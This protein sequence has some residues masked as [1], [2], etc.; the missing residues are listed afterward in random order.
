M[1]IALCP[2]LRFKVNPFCGNLGGGLVQEKKEDRYALRKCKK[3]IPKHM[4]KQYRKK[5]GK[6]KREKGRRKEEKGKKRLAK[7]SGKFFRS[8][9]KRKRFLM[10]KYRSKRRK[11]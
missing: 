11:T 10:G 2:D 6:K 1:P 8:K 4:L 5:K 9:V 7:N 3:K